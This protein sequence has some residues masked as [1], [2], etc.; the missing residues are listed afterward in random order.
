M[1]MTMVTKKKGT[2]Y[3]AGEFKARCL[4]LMERVAST[5]TPILVTKRGKP[6]VQI[7]PAAEKEWD[8]STW[9]ERGRATLILPPSD[10]EITRPTGVKWN[11][12]R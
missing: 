2:S 10:E 6:L 9:R 1:I 7:V 8:E 4:R 3:G 5:R 11:A 12:E